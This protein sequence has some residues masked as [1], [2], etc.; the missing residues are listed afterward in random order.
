MPTNDLV[1]DRVALEQELAYYLHQRNLIEK[2]R[3]TARYRLGYYSEI[4]RRIRACNEA[5][6]T[7][8]NLEDALSTSDEFVIRYNAS[9]G[10]PKKWKNRARELHMICLR[11]QAA[12]VKA[13]YDTAKFTLKTT[14]RVRYIARILD[15]RIM[16]REGFV[17]GFAPIERNPRYIN[18][19]DADRFVDRDQMASMYR[20]HEARKAVES[21]LEGKFDGNKKS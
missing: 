5:M 4:K 2:R 7:Y 15:V 1:D 11:Y 8:G 14:K 9:K 18:S 12:Y 13:K 6:R 21:M 16:Y 19:I 3:S 10:Y 20:E 17:H